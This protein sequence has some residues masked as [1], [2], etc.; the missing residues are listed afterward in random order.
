MKLLLV[1]L[2]AISLLSAADLKLGKPLA[3]QSPI[4]LATLISHSDDYAGKT[5]QVKGKIAAVCQEMG[6][7]MEL[8]NDSGQKLRIQV[9]DGEIEFPK[10]AA[11]KTA[12]AEGKFTKTVLTREQAIEQAQEDAKD[13]GKKF[14]PASIK[15][16]VT[17]YQIQGTGAVIQGN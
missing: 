9:K 5:V 12:I 11:G 8:V 3:A 13:S 6:C 16:G 1:T 7:W 17:S 10:D 4:A 15:S 2:T 14:D